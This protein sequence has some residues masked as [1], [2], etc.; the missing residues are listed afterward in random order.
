VKRTPIFRAATSVLLLS[1]ACTPGDVAQDSPTIPQPEP[2]PEPPSPELPAAPPPSHDGPG[3]PGVPCQL[4]ADC[5]AGNFCELRMC[6]AGCPE[7]F[8]C[9]AGEVCDPHGR[10]GNAGEEDTTRSFAG[11]PALVDRRTVLAFGQTQ[12]RTTLRNDG[13][14]TLS[15]R[16]AGASS[17]LALDTAPAELAPGAEVE[18]VADLDLAALAPAD[19]VLP[20]QIIT[21]GGALLW[22]LE[23]DALPESGQ[24]RG[25]VSFDADG[26]S[27]ASSDLTVDLDFRDDGTIAGRV[28]TDASLLWPQPLALSGTWNAAGDISLILRD[29]LPAENWRHSPL[30]RELGRVLVLTGTRTATGLEGTA[31]ETITGLRT[32]AVKVQGAFALRR[33]GPLMGLILADDFVPKDAAPPTWL[34]PPGLD[35]SACDGLGI[36]YGTARR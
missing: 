13:T 2:S 17:A 12:A 25:V 20:V 30:A 11:L 26:F 19:R 3:S 32:A 6:I 22:A 34:A 15:Y 24:F 27:L 10:C 1:L 31:I 33:Q 36:L 8:A 28:D 16:L 35:A 18:L 7:A 14:E 29:R 9:D 21:S 4:D 5:G 23:L